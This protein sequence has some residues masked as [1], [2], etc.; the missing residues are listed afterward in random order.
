IFM[1][2]PRDE[3]NSLLWGS[4]TSKIFQRGE[5][6][7]KR[8]HETIHS[9]ETPSA[10]DTFAVTQDMAGFDP[11]ELVVKLVGEKVVLTGRK[12]SEMP[13]GPFR[14]ELFRRAWDVPQSVDRDQLSCSISSDGQLRIEGPVT[15][16]A[17]R[18]V[19]IAVNRVRNEPQPA[20]E[21]STPTENSRAQG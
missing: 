15:E 2:C 3:L 4:I 1:K 5:N 16:A 9:L 7:N 13:N 17:M 14:Y 11:Q 21:E 18:T 19:P 6:L 12:A 10:N 20:A 8:D